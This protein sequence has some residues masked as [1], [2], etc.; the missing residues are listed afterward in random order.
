[1]SI[2]NTLYYIIKKGSL[3]YAEIS[4]GK[5]PMQWTMDGLASVVS[6]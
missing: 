4:Y 1:M 3:L 6:R 2:V 5:G